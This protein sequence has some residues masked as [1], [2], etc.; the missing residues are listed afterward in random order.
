MRVL[1]QLPHATNLIAQLADDPDGAGRARDIGEKRRVS[2]V[3]RIKVPFLLPRRLRFAVQADR[4]ITGTPWRL[5][6]RLAGLARDDRLLFV[7]PPYKR[8]C[9]IQG[10]VAG[11]GEKGRTALAV[12]PKA[13]NTFDDGT[14]DHVSGRVRR[15]R[16]P[17]SAIFGI[18][19]HSVSSFQCCS[20]PAYF[21]AVARNSFMAA[22][23]K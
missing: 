20:P 1:P 19:C 22:S 12:G 11:A 7:V 16:K 8:V 18:V 9:D 3:H 23:A 13:I 15:V 6:H 14:P 4:R 17:V 5:R 21:R 2:G 10:N